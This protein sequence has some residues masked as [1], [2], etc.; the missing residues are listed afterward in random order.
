MSRNWWQ[1]EKRPPSQVLRVTAHLWTAFALAIMIASYFARDE[2]SAA[3]GGGASCFAVAGY[4]YRRAQIAER[5]EAKN[6]AP[7]HQ[8]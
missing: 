6:P 2:R 3:I 1:Y 7:S 5:N 4:F 8:S